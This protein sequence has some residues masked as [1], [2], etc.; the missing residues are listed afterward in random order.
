MAPA[1]AQTNAF[2]SPMLARLDSIQ[3]D[4]ATLRNDLSQ[5]AGQMALVQSEAMSARQQPMAQGTHAAGFAQA[6]L[7]LPQEAI[8]ALCALPAALA[9]TKL[10]RS[11]VDVKGLGKPTRF[12]GQEDDTVSWQRRVKNYLRGIFEQSRSVLS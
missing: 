3:A 8:Q 11:L 5:E 1:K 2:S 7:T 9:S 4:S 12:S 10:K 6:R